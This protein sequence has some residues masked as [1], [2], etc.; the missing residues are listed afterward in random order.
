MLMSLSVDENIPLLVSRFRFCG[1]SGF[2]LD[3][4]EEF[5]DPLPERSDAGSLFPEA[6]AFAHR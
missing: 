6:N 1:I 4:N 5:G 2:C 3:N